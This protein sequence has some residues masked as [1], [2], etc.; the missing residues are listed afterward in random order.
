MFFWVALVVMIVVVAS[1]IAWASRG[2]AERS[3]EP[4]TQRLVERKD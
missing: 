4:G 3:H 2:V 1:L